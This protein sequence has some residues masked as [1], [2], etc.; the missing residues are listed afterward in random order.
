MKKFITLLLVAGWVLVSY[1]QEVIQLEETELTFTPTA[2]VVF[3]DYSNGIIKVKENFAKQFQ[4][5]AIKFLV[6]NFDIHR[7]IRESDEE[8]NE[9][10]VTVKSSNGTLYATYDKN[11]ELV[12]TFQKFKDVPLPSDIRNQLFASHGMGWEMLKNRY[13]A[14][15]KE[16]NIDNE[17]YVVYMKN[18]NKKDK[19]KITPNRATG[20]ASIEY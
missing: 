5:N 17:S 9:I 1:S 13:I 10:K 20:V 12:N 8:F 16:D 3:E 15:G 11:G 7:F 18:G 2:E 4:D 6:D 19:L 14:S